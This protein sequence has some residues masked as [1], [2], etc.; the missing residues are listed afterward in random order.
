MQVALIDLITKGVSDYSLIKAVVHAEFNTSITRYSNRTRD[1]LAAIA[2][3]AVFTYSSS[4]T[5]SFGAGSS[6]ARSSTRDEIRIRN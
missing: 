4:P 6:S 2:P 3:H 1:M 5:P